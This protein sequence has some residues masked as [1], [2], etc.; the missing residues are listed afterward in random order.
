MLPTIFTWRDALDTLM[1]TNPLIAMAYSL[2][3]PTI[4]WW[5]EALDTL[6]ATNPLF[7][8]ACSTWADIVTG[9][10]GVIVK[11]HRPYST[12]HHAGERRPRQAAVPRAQ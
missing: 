11:H 10:S 9:G 8:A 5:R 4:T 3:L 1:A 7:A 2:K 6:A 12:A